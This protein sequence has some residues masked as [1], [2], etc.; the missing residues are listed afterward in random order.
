MGLGAH[1]ELA[2]ARFTEMILFAVVGMATVLVLGGSA[3][4]TGLWDDH[5]VC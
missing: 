3:R 1:T 5:G 4:W 2:F